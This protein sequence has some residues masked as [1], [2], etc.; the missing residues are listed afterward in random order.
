MVDH[1]FSERAFSDEPT[2]SP[3]TTAWKLDVPVWEWFASPG[4]ELRLNRFGVAMQGTQA[5]F[6]PEAIL[7]GALPQRLSRTQW[8][9]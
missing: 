2:A 6:K 3:I 7:E 4:N 5:I 1:V 8:L 9:T